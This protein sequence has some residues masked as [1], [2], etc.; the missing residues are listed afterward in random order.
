MNRRIKIVAVPLDQ[1]IEC[2]FPTQ[3]PY[4]CLS[5]LRLNP[6]PADYDIVDA[7]YNYLN[8]C[9]DV[10]VT[11]PSFEEVP[12]GELTPRL[13]DGCAEFVQYARIEDDASCSLQSETERAA[14][15]AE[16]AEIESRSIRSLDE[17]C[18]L[19]DLWGRHN[20]LNASDLPV[21]RER[22]DQG[23]RADSYKHLGGPHLGG[24]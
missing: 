17:A 18:H 4:S 5:R 11:H 10:I 19:N 7:H 2:L 15:I 13:I 6:L 9:L 14:I 16:I 22:R 20:R 12:Q 24:A 23:Q 3:R 8:C 1:V 21:Y